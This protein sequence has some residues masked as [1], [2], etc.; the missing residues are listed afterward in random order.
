M[1]APA[2]EKFHGVDGYREP[3]EYAKGG[4]F[5]RKSYIIQNIRAS[6]CIRRSSALHQFSK[7]LPCKLIICRLNVVHVAMGKNYRRWRLNVARWTD[8]IWKTLRIQIRVFLK[9]ERRDCRYRD[10]LVLAQMVELE[11]STM[12]R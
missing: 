9:R 1:R 8:S 10:A 3:V 2:N 6:I 11:S 12:E 5:V 7:S 4:M